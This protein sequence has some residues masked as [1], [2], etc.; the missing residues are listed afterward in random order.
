MGLPLIL[1]ILVSGAGIALT[2][3]WQRA[4]WKSQC[5][6]AARKIHM[7]MAALY[8]GE[9]R[10]RVVRETDFPN[11]DLTGYREARTLLTGRGFSFLGAIENLTLTAVYPENRT[12]MAAYADERGT[13]CAFFYQV[14]QVRV[15][16]FSTGLGGDRVLLTNNAE[17]DRLTP[18]PSVS[19]E[20]LPH[21]TPPEMILARHLERLASLRAAEPAVA[22]RS[23]T[24]LDDVLDSCGRFSRLVADH[25]RS[26]GLL[27]EAEMLRLSAPGQEPTA[28]QVFEYFR[29]RVE[30]EESA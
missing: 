28:R 25:R 30:H 22:P 26:V 17:A 1:F 13:T 29:E 24:S 23:V 12:F 11:L 4:R 18:A 5:R 16:D 8:C 9:A 14:Q 15:H 20:T 2:V 21:D 6:A 7:E 3:A 19:R 27:T 10:F